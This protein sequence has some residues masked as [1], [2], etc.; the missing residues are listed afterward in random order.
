MCRMILRDHLS[1]DPR[2]LSL[3][4][5]GKQIPSDLKRGIDVPV[6]IPPLPDELTYQNAAIDIVFDL[7]V[8]KCL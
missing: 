3:R 5:F 1:V 2:Q 8:G 7:G 6:F 4:Q